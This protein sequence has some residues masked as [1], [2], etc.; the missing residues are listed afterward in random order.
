MEI[1]LE[2]LAMNNLFKNIPLDL[3]K[4]VFSKVTVKNYEKGLI[5]FNEGEQ[6]NNIGFISKGSLLI[7]QITIAGDAVTI[8]IYKTFDCFGEA[9]FFGE[10]KKYPYNFITNEETQVIYLSFE[11]ICNLISVSPEFTRN[12]LG[13]LSDKLLVLKDK[14]EILSQKD[15]RSKL[16]NYFL[17]ESRL[18]NSLTFKL[19]HT[20]TQI[21]ELVNV[22]R[23]SVSREIR[24]MQLDNIIEYKDNIITL[25]ET[26]I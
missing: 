17:N 18:V 23:P 9:L 5:I 24:H 12:Y 22:T 19:R 2:I 14:I 20:K 4:K 3:L 6:C 10:H 8:S 21:A 1:N 11:Q 15:V 25:L 13:V 26:M 7:E 16:M